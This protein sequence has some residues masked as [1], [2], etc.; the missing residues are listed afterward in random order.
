MKETVFYI[1][2]IALAIS[3]VIVSF[4]GLKV[5]KFPG[6]L[7]VVVILVFA[8]GAIGAATFA[9]LYSK[10]HEEH[11]E[12]ELEHANEVF[13]SEEHGGP[14]E[15]GEEE[16][17]GSEGG[18]ETGGESGGGEASGPGGTLEVIANETNIAYEESSLET[19]AGEVEIDFKNPSAIEHDV[20]VEK[21]GEE[22]GGTDVVTDGEASGTVELEP[23]EYTFF[24]SIPGHRE[25]GMEGPLTV[26]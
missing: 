5:E 26:K 18:E 14:F 20:K 12:H 10:E 15:E 25:A 17:G 23:G 6:K 1:V 11:R 16:H 9:V 19:E 2:G 4:I 21:D 7:S 13:E 3:A 22:I 8:A 24:C